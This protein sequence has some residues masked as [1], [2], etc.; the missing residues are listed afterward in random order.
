[1]AR[2]KHWTSSKENRCG[3]KDHKYSHESY[4]VILALP[5]WYTLICQSRGS[6]ITLS[7][8]RF[9]LFSWTSLV[10]ILFKAGAFYR[11]CA[12]KG[13]SAHSSSDRN[14]VTSLRITL[15]EKKV[16]MC[17]LKSRSSYNKSKLSYTLILKDPNDGQW[18]V[19]KKL[20]MG[21]NISKKSKWLMSFSLIT[22]HFHC[23]E[24]FPFQI[25]PVPLLSKRYW[26]TSQH[27]F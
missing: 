6:W 22:A 10:R 21:K 9:F 25:N 16:Q 15:Q 20:K 3:Q 5:S 13:V 19:M 17:Y 27:F 23:M 4:R 14:E 1:M 8:H 26:D 24:I 12:G 2:N 7:E 11:R 18:R